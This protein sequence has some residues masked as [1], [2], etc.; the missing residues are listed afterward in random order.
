MT[1]GKAP[2]PH[3]SDDAEQ[4]DIRDEVQIHEPDSLP[5]D[6]GSHLTHPQNE[7]N[8]LPQI[9]RQKAVAGTG[10]SFECSPSRNDSQI[11]MCIA[12]IKPQGY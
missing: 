8:D 9:G 7:D 5:E 1:A 3:E 2:T 11:N 4:Q 10:C 12:T 6:N